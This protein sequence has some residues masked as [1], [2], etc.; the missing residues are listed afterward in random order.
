[1][2]PQLK[3]LCSVQVI[4]EASLIGWDRGEHTKLVGGFNPFEKY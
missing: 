4:L 2:L 1:M 3:A